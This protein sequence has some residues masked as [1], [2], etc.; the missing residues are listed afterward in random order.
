MAKELTLQ[1][2]DLDSLPERIRASSFDENAAREML[3]LIEANKAGSDMKSYDTPELAR[4]AG[5]RFSRALVRVLADD[6]NRKPTIRTF[7]IAKNGKPAKLP[8]EASAYGFVISLKTPAEQ[9]AEA[10]EAKS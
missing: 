6:D 5:V 7:G 1:A 10:A 3:A 2:F 9:A 4:N 8:S